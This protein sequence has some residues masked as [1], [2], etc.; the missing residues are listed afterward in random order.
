[1]LSSSISQLVD[2][3]KIITEHLA[4][5]SDS[6]D[7]VIAVNPN[8]I[9]SITEKNKLKS[10]KK[11]INKERVFNYNSNIITLYGY[12]EQYIEALIEEYINNLVGI[13]EK[14]DNNNSTIKQ[15]FFN[16]WERLY[17]KLAYPK[18]AHLTEEVL[19]QSLYNSRITNINHLIPEYYYQNGGNYKHSVI[20]ECF[21]GLGIENVSQMI[22]VY[23]PLHSYF[24]NK[25]IYNQNDDILY[26][27]LN[28]LVARRN[29]VAHGNNSTILDISYF[30]EYVDYIE[31][32]AK[33]LNA[34]LVDNLYMQ[35]WETT[36]SQIID[37]KHLYHNRII[38]IEVE[39]FVVE[40]G[41]KI[42]VKEPDG[43]FPRFSIREVK[44]IHKN[45]IARN[46]FLTYVKDTVAL[47]LSMN[48]KR[49]CKF[50]MLC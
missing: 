37:I 12:F 34:L 23:E 13:I 16:K 11:R 17:N 15:Q 26:E 38:E 18:Y 32:Y 21:A 31:M 40:V 28:D 3:I 6:K 4:Y 48:I 9:S 27:I 19:I 50:K 39:D 47:G 33:S 42:L 45:N 10:L 1:M 7:L 29:D 8:A 46:D 43:N 41:H 14:F 30:R 22:K 20:C 49:K 24:K 44:S 25:G 2:N 35:K 36:N 5:L